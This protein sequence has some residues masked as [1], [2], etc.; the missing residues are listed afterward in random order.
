[1]CSPSLP[2]EA[3]GAMSIANATGSDTGGGLDVADAHD[4]SSV[5]KGVGQLQD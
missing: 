1:V 2:A 3:A 4:A 5:N